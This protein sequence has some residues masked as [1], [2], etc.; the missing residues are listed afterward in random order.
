LKL[1]GNPFE[2]DAEDD[3]RS[4]PSATKASVVQETEKSSE[5]EPSDESEV[6]TESSE[7]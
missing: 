4:V 3:I 5:T 7:E 6:K 1:I 2:A